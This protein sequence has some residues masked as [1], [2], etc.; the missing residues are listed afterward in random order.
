MASVYAGQR[1]LPH[2][3]SNIRVLKQI[4]GNVA[5]YDSGAAG[6][7][8]SAGKPDPVDVR[9]SVE[10]TLRDP[11]GRQIAPIAVS[12]GRRTPSPFGG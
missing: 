5:D 1:G 9:S 7:R 2:T 3:R 4:G 6:R 8:A 10:V 11:Q 12:S